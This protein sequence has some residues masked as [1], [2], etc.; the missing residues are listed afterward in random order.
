MHGKIR[1]QWEHLPPFLKANELEFRHLRIVNR[2]NNAMVQG[3]ASSVSPG[4]S[5]GFQRAILDEF[6]QI[7]HNSERIMASVGPACPRGIVILSTPNGMGNAFARIV[8]EEARSVFPNED[9]PNPNKH[10]I[11]LAL[12]WS[13]HPLR[14][15]GKW[16]ARE[17]NRK[18]MTAEMIAQEYEIDF[19]GSKGRRVYP[20]YIE[21]RHRSGASLCPIPA[22]YHPYRPHAL[23][24]DFNHDPL[25]WEL[26]QIYAQ[27][28][29][30]RV[31]GE[32]C[33][34]D[35][36]FLDGVWEFIVR[37]ASRAYLDKFLAE[38]EHHGWESIY[39]GGGVCIA[40]DQGH[41]APIVIYG[42]ATEE[43]KTHMTCV[44]TYDD[45]VGKLK[46]AGFDVRR[47]VPP[48]N[49]PVDRRIETHND[50]LDRNLVV[51]ALECEQL[52]KDYLHGTWDHSQKDMEQHKEDDDGSHLTRS[53]GS[54]AF[55][56]FLYQHHKVGTSGGAATRTPVDKT[57]SPKSLGSDFIKSWNR[58]VRR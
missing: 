43:K 50:A 53:H 20:K 10:W 31:V 58:P 19:L 48:S 24:C 1:F 45:I 27:P 13:T 3:Y 23:C 25:V 38:P 54:S 34:R 26:V 46:A 47:K 42:D 37:F 52:R 44:K 32:I 57:G 41:L 40:G 15:D 21:E 51:V 12:H 35:A 28:P 18:S 17:L 33:R 56:Y 39:G 36:M 55:G 29:N 8:H 4:R 49:P 14:S 9:P 30:Y 5:G 11:K 22:I 2:T 16:K 6:A 7:E